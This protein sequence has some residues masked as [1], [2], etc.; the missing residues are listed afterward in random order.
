VHAVTQLASNVSR[1][2]FGWRHI[3]PAIIPAFTLGALAGAWLGSE[4]YQSLDARW[5]PACIGLFLLWF[6]WAPMPRVPGGGQ[7][8]LLLLGIYQTGLGM[9]AGAT[10][11]VGGA[12]L[13]RRNT[14]RDWLVVNTAVYM[15]LN[16]TLRLAAFVAIGFSF[17]PWWQLVAGMVV[18]V[19]LG[20]WVG[21]R[22][23]SRM[24][25]LN[26]QRLFRIMVTLLALRMIALSLLAA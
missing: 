9:L 26:F 19:I 7:L 23:R 11:P 18:A 14:A 12:V 21:T 24:P 8:A 1:A 13:M 22:L 17:A 5:L 10:G 3:D 2:G 4:I 16:H 15:T 20:S 25:Q 6:T